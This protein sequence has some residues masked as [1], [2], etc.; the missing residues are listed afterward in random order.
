VLKAVVVGIGR[1]GWRYMLSG[2]Q[3]SHVSS[4]LKCPKTELVAVADVDRVKL[5]DFKIEHPDIAVYADYEKMLHEVK[6]DIVSVATPVDTHCKIVRNVARFNCVKVVFCEKPISSTI[7]DAGKMTRTCEEFQV[8]LC[9]NHTRRYDQAYRRIKRIV[10]GEDDTWNIGEPL[11]FSG[12]FSSGRIR[13]GV[14]M[15]DLYNFYCREKTELSLL[16]LPIPHSVVFEVDLFCERG[17][18]RVLDNGYDIQLW[19]LEE[20]QRWSGPQGPLRVLGGMVTLEE[21][22]DFSSAMLSAVEDLVECA[23]SDKQPEC[24][25]GCGLEALKLCL[26]KVNL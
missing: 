17:L 14:H 21:T 13:E 7:E 22:Y 20:S 4:Y 26:E 23:T 1:I 5:E 12:R 24:D 9:I 18:I 2:E 3:A 11:A 16:N 19:F 15:A 8:K 6:P 25:G 10:D